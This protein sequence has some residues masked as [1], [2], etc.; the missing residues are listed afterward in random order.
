[1]KTKKTGSVIPPLVAGVVISVSLTVLQKLGVNSPIS[2]VGA[3]VF[4][5][6]SYL[7]NLVIFYKKI[8]INKR[9]EKNHDGGKS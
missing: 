6:V 4:G 1:M 9:K 8:E 7:V 3:I 2:F 5:V